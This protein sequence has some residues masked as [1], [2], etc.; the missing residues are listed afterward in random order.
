LGLK[1]QVAIVTGASSGIGRACALALAAAGCKVA[2]NHLPRSEAAANEVAAEIAK[3]GGEAMTV[4]ADVSAEA[5]VEAMF[6]TVRRRFGTVHIL[7]NNAG[8]QA[9]AS[10]PEMTFEQWRKV[11]AVNLDG[12]FLCSRAAVR[13]FM[14]RGLEPEV[15]PALG[16]IIC[17]SSVHETI[18][19]AFESN[20]AASKGGVRLLMQS[21][22]QELAPHKIRVNS[23]APG[24]IKTAINRAAW[25]TPEALQSLLKLIP[26]GRVGEGEDV[27]RVA[28]FLASD[29]SDYITGAT[30]FVDGGM[31]LYPAFRGAG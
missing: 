12:Y 11:L 22:A 7:L 23:I 30:I 1:G 17:I 10:F 5:D 25:E 18:P 31:A 19:W 4:A 29:L 20:Y 28:R 24:A 3:S 13:E 9:G 6:A 21:L 16:K 15:S 27:A 14:R 8:I 26:Y 2:V